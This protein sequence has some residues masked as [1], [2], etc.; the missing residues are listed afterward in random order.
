MVVHPGVV[1][2]AI[3]TKEE[4]TIPIHYNVSKVG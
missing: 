3:T 1:V 4:V 2:R